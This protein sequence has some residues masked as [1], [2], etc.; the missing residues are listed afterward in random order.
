[1]RSKGQVKGKLTD[2]RAVGALLTRGPHAVKSVHVQF[3]NGFGYCLSSVY[4]LSLATLQFV[5]SSRRKNNRRI[6]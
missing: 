4:L 2:A 3:Q 5:H 1:M 6:A